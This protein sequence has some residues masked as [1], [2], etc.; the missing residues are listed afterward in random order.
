MFTILSG[1]NLDDYSDFR[2]QEREKSDAYQATLSRTGKWAVKIFRPGLI[3]F[4]KHMDDT[5]WGPLP[6]EIDAAIQMIA[7]R[8]EARILPHVETGRVA[9]REDYRE[10]NL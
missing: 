5:F 2:S 10:E 4:V 7:D 6:V 1:L 9:T 8:P 3:S